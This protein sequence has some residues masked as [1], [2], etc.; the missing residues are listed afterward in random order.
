[1]NQYWTD[2]IYGGKSLL[3]GLAI[4]A[5][6]FFSPVVTEQYPYE[7]PTMTPLFRG[8]TELIG[9]EET[10]LPNCVVCGACPRACPS[11]CIT[12]EG[13][14]A[15]SGKGR[16]LTRYILDFSKCSLCG[17]CVESCKFNAL[18]FS[19][20]YNLVSFDKDD[21]IYMDLMKRLEE[22]NRCKK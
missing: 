10:G 2:I 4:T 20:D 3:T 18:R 21:F 16:V 8:H 12:L 19:R 11:N 9:N 1:M 15:E 17:L 14:K 5:R 7:V 6:E 22:Q 13:K